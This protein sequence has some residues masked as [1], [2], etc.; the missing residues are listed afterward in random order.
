MEGKALVTSIFIAHGLLSD[1]LGRPLDFTEPI[2]SVLHTVTN[3]PR[4]ND[5]QAVELASD[6]ASKVQ[7]EVKKDQ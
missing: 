2:A 4:G 5:A 3:I 6:G 1:L 7:K